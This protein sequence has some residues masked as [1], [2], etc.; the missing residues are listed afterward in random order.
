MENKKDLDEKLKSFAK[1]LIKQKDSHSK[2]D[3]FQSIAGSFKEEEI[4]MEYGN[5]LREFYR[6]FPESKLKEKDNS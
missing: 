2:D 6:L 1:Y 3:P 5:T 4:S